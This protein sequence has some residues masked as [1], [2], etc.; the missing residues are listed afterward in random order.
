MKQPTRNHSLVVDTNTSWGP[1]RACSILRGGSSVH[2]RGYWELSRFQMVAIQAEMQSTRP[3]RNQTE[4]RHGNRAKTAWMIQ[5][6]LRSIDSFELP[7]TFNYM[8]VHKWG[9]PNWWFIMES[10][11]KMDDWRYPY[12]K[13]PY[14]TTFHSFKPEKSLATPRFQ[15]P[16]PIPVDHG[17]IESAQCPWWVDRTVALLRKAPLWDFHPKKSLERN[18]GWFWMV[19]D[20]SRWFWSMFS[21]EIKID[22]RSYCIT[23]LLKESRGKFGSQGSWKRIWN[24]SGIEIKSSTGFTWG[25]PTHMFCNC[26]CSFILMESIRTWEMTSH[27]GLWYCITQLNLKCL[28]RPSMV[29]KNLFQVDFG[30]RKDS[31]WTQKNRH[32]CSFVGWTTNIVWACLNHHNSFVLSPFLVQEANRATGLI[33]PKASSRNLRP[34]WNLILGCKDW[35]DYIGLIA[36]YLKGL[37]CLRDL[38]YYISALDV[39][40]WWARPSDLRSDLNPAAKISRH[41]KPGTNNIDMDI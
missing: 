16:S 3:S 21:F 10:P 41:N 30:P 36:S 7:I 40:K 38:Y 39:H 26:I 29:A 4:N 20:G 8:G 14:D 15:R 23:S 11:L 17:L 5:V 28:Q 1:F 31:C 34:V 2:V 19:L 32:V 6:R 25:I 9:Y 37:L 13:P 18:S 35:L 27:Q 24:H 33:K 12:R 22:T